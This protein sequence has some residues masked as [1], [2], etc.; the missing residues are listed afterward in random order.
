MYK[1]KNACK[2]IKRLIKRNKNILY[3]P[4]LPEYKYK[5]N[6]TRQERYNRMLYEGFIFLLPQG[7]IGPQFRLANY[8]FEHIPDFKRSIKY[9]EIG[10]FCGGNALSVAESYARYDNSEIHCVDPWIEYDEDGISAYDNMNN[11]YEQFNKNLDLSLHKEKFK[12][13]RNFSHSIVP[14]FEDNIFDL[15]YIDGNHGVL[16]V[17]EDAIISFRKLKN[18]GYM[19]F[20]DVDWRNTTQ[21]M[22][23]FLHMYKNFI[24]FI[25]FDNYQLFIKKIKEL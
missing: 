14:T 18:G 15:I 23:I 17:L 12:I 19:I 13:H 3:L 24:Q 25:A 9:L 21:S 10:V 11:I 22:I 6:E 16:N 5:T 1:I 4:D 8:W 2:K 7:Y 20:D